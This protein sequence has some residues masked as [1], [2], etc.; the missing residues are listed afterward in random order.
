MPLAI[1]SLVESSLPQSMSCADAWFPMI[2]HEFPGWIVDEVPRLVSF[3]DLQTLLTVITTYATGDHHNKC[4]GIYYKLLN[5]Y[6]GLEIDC[7][8]ME[9]GDED[10]DE[11]ED[12]GGW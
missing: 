9:D 4:P 10:G 3:N 5:T 2:M 12:Y 1:K 7:S 11:D 6:T 8:V